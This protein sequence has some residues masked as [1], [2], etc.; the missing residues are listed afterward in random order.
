MPR[1]PRSTQRCELAAGDPAAAEVVE[2]RALALLLVEVVQLGHGRL[3]GGWVRF[4]RSARSCAGPLGDV[5]GGEAELAPGPCCPGRRRRSGRCV[6]ESS[7]QRSQPNDDAGLDRERGD[8]GGEHVDLVVARPAR[9]RAPSTAS[10]RPG[11]RRPR[12]RARSA[13]ST[14]THTSLPVPMSTRSGVVR[15]GPSSVSDVGAPGARRRCRRCPRARAGPG[16]SG[17]RAVGPSWS[18][19]I[20]PGRGG[21][22]GV[23]RADDPQARAWPA[24]RPGARSAGGSGRPRRGPTRVVGP[25][26]DDL[27]LAERGEPDGAAHVVAEDEERAADRQQRRRAGPCRS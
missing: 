9:R 13:A 7:A 24:A 27:G 15:S 2:P 18:T 10:T 5:L 11:R 26:V 8:V 12:R 6:T 22:V 16:G 20:A 23:G 25:G 17:T 4:G 1:T 3:L 14:H 19:A 21:L